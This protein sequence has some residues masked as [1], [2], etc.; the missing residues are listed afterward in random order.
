M[1]K[2][3]NQTATREPIP[4]FLIGLAPESLADLSWTDPALGVSDCAW[5]PED[6][7]SPALGQ[8]EVYGEETFTL[9]DGVVIVTRTVLPMPQNEID[10]LT[11]KEAAQVRADR[12]AKLSESDW[13]Q[14]ADA[15]VDQAAWAA[16]RQALRDVTVQ[17][18]FPWSVN[19][20]T[21]P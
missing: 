2:I 6:D 19:W 1:I 7:A 16:Y 18:G 14:V 8:F 10:A 20:P 11:A 17:A 15:P 12:N 9:G 5:W 21:Q 4:N 13:T 3:Q